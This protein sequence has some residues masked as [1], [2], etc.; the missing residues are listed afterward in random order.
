MHCAAFLL[1]MY[2]MDT[3]IS[4]ANSL[5]HT[6]Q[7]QSLATPQT[8]Q[9]SSASQTSSTFQQPSPKLPPIPTPSLLSFDFH[10]MNTRDL[11]RLL[12]NF[13]HKNTIISEQIR[14]KISIKLD[15]VTW[16]EA[17]AVVLKMQGLIEQEEGNTIFIA[18]VND[19]AKYDQ[20]AK[21]QLQ[22]QQLQQT[23][24][25][26]LLTLKHA[27]VE[28]VAAILTKQNNLISN[29]SISV[30][31]QNNSLLVNA[32]TPPQLASIQQI[33]QTLDVPT[34]QVLIEGQ[35]VIADDKVA[36]ELGLKFGTTNTGGENGNGNNGS[37]NSKSGNMNMDLPFTTMSPGHF[38]IAIAKLGQGIIL[39]ME[40]AALESVGHARIISSPKLITTN[41]QAAY[42]ESGQEIPYQEK[43]SSG[44]TSVAFKKAVLSLKATPNII[45]AN[46]L[47]LNLNLNQDKVSD[48]AVNG[49]P[50]IQTQQMQT[51][52]TLNSGET[53][54]L[55]G[56]YEYSTIENMTRIPI[57]GAIPV[58]G[59]LFRN[60]NVEVARKELLILITPQII[61]G[62]IN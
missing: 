3:D 13:A 61:N 46:K 31:K 5:P 11:L 29:S 58:L 23:Q 21:Q 47:I 60:K 32:A 10:D 8:Y 15:R 38:G 41:N 56:I 45:S 44:A 49:V 35:I 4:A 57:L 12:T 2:F 27:P 1:A 54:I 22:Q 39:N 43:T 59:Y 30:N 62:D 52:V 55:G 18:P 6:Q 19:M 48:I 14:G 26:S 7:R 9:V 24:L 40:L 53:V 50:A 20:I 28:E 33:A 37:G 34:R 16:Q 17:L 42:I 36:D 25:P 51:Q